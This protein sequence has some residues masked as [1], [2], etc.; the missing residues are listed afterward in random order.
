MRVLS[1][2]AFLSRD[3][4]SEGT[5]VP[6]RICGEDILH[7]PGS[8]TLPTISG[9]AEE[10]HEVPTSSAVFGSSSTPGPGPQLRDRDA[11]VVNSSRS[12]SRMPPEYRTVCSK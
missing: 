11:G 5:P 7:P 12:M 6:P 3:I 8:Y 9:Y 1:I 10:T 4:A 2:E